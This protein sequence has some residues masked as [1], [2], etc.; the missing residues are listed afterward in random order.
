MKIICFCILSLLISKWAHTQIDC[1]NC[2]CF[3]ND[4]YLWKAFVGKSGKEF[5][6]K[7]D[8]LD[9]I[10]NNTKMIVQFFNKEYRIQIKLLRI[11]TRVAYLKII[12]SEYFTQQIGDAAANWYMAELVYSLTEGSLITKVF[13]NFEEGDH[14][15]TPGYKTR[16]SFKEYIICKKN[17]L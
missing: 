7:G 10:K 14:G 12:N 16:K 17:S 8:S 1:N 6:V 9:R 11:K 4:S 2:T 3:I 13:I 15:G 5:L